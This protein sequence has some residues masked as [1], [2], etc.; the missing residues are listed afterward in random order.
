M[1]SA[2]KMIA[3][4]DDELVL[5]LEDA[6]QSELKSDLA[7][8]I[9][10]AKKSGYKVSV[11]RLLEV[12]GLF[13]PHRSAEASL[14]VL[15]FSPN[16]ESIDRRLE[17]FSLTLAFEA[18]PGADPDDDPPYIVSYAP[19]QEGE[20][21]FSEHE[22]TVTKTRS[23]EISG[24]AQPPV[25][26][27]SLGL[28]ASG[29]QQEESQRRDLYRLA[30]ESWR[31]PGLSE[32][33]VV[34]WRMKAAT[35]V[36]G[37]G[38]SIGVAVL[39]RRARSSKFSIRLEVEADLG[40]R[41]QVSEKMSK[42]FNA[43]KKDKRARLGP[44]GPGKGVQSIPEGQSIPDGVDLNNLHDS[45]TKN[46]LDKLA[47]VHVAE[48]VATKEYYSDGMAVPCCQ[49]LISSLYYVRSFGTEC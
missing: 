25:G 39:L 40:F 29:S 18:A 28:T 24:S 34:R 38:D 33:N 45:S 36:E 10:T 37:I 16:A 19:G 21:Y 30:T 22:T 5:N 46:I 44:F 42:T 15:K 1:A 9:G 35:K 20:T 12:H 49:T 17:A 48:H 26:G 7:P 3:I 8:I 2:Q 23:I 14:L 32:P 6:E 27:A 11:Q 4:G 43:L 41:A 31:D 47:F 13:E